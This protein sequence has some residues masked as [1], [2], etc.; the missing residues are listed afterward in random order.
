[1]SAFRPS[2]DQ[3]GSPVIRH[4][5]L[6]RALLTLALVVAAAMSPQSSYARVL[7]SLL[8]VITLILEL[9][10]F[11]G[12][13]VA[14]SLV[15][16]LSRAAS[17]IR[18]QLPA[19]SRPLW[20]GLPAPDPSS[21][22]AGLLR[23]GTELDD[24]AQLLRET[25]ADRSLERDKLRS[26]IDAVDEPVIATSAPGEVV[27]ANAAAEQ[28]LGR[29]GSAVVGRAIDDIF[30][31]A[32]VMG[33]HAAALGGKTLRAT[34]RMG[35]TGSVRTYQVIAAP[36]KTGRRIVGSST[37]APGTTDGVVLA[38]RDV[39]ELAMAVQL[40]SDF[41]AN[42]SHELRTPLAAIR[43]AVET[44]QGDEEGDPAMRARL[45]QMIQVHTTRLEELTRD[46]LDLSRLE[47]PDAGVSIT[48]VRASEVVESLAAYFEASCMERRLRLVFD[49]APELESMRTDPRLLDLVL[50]NL[51]DN[52]TKFAY[53]DT[54]I[55]VTGHVIPP[56]RQTADRPGVRFQVT[57]A[58]AGIPLAS[59]QR[60]FE[61]FYQVDTARTGS[62]PRRGTG[63]GLAIVKHAVKAL[64][65]NIKVDS[66][67]KQGTTMTVEIPACVEV[68]G[69]ASSADGP[70][71]DVAQRSQSSGA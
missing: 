39:T 37:G 13:P 27:L 30:T 10:G 17:E 11:W 24:I 15:A 43:T 41:V 32:E 33:M 56:A 18:S 68:E 45:L 50:R 29:P 48:D 70:P 47:S 14:Q 60:I 66:V 34:I 19:P 36:L 4:G 5:R 55:V 51:I 62:V 65:G 67:W 2:R 22:V 7:L 31:Q 8:A 59:Q 42:A 63:L 12:A 28:L 44:I 16:R 25:L 57:D 58:G 6:L 54:A 23:L 20:D 61:R 35:R 49:M 1:M 3:I 52:S 53:P 21:P 38:L 64:G 71:V 9:T 26:I 69:S 40:K 46:L